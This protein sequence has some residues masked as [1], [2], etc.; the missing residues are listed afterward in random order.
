MER[1]KTSARE[2]I[3]QRYMLLI[4]VIGFIAIILSLP[5]IEWPSSYS[6][7]F[8][9]ILFLV[10]T[11]F[12]SIPIGKGSTT[13]GFPIVFTFDFLF[14][15]SLTLIVYSLVV[16]TINFVQ[17][18]PTRVAFFNSA[19]LILSF[20]AAKGILIF[21]YTLFINET[22]SVSERVT[23]AIIFTVLFYIFNELFV[24]IV[25]WI[26]PQPYTLVEWKQRVAVE[27]IGMM[28]SAIYLTLFF[29]LGT[30]NR[31]E[32]DIFSF[33]FFFS[34]LV[35]LSL[36]GASHFK[37]RIEKKRLQGLISIKK[38]LNP[39]ISERDWLK[40]LEKNLPKLFDYDAFSI[41]IKEDG[42]WDCQFSHG[43][44]SHLIENMELDKII[45]ESGGHLITVSPLAKAESFYQK[46][47]LASIKCGIYCPLIVDE[48][49]KGLM[50]IGRMRPQQTRP[51][52]NEMINAL[53]NQIE[54]LIKGR[55][56][57]SERERRMILEE[58]NRIAREI[59]DGIAQSVAGTV[60][61]LEVANRHS[62]DRPQQAFEILR[63]VLPELRGSLK[64]IRESIFALRP[65]PTEKHGLPQAIAEE[66]N[67]LNETH[68]NVHIHLMERGNHQTL[69]PEIEKMTF[70]IFK[71]SIQNALKHASASKI[72]TILDYQ[73]ERV[74]MNIK[75]NGSGFRLNEALLK[76]QKGNHFGILNMNEEASKLDA[77]LEINSFV[78]K[79]TN[80]LL[81]TPVYSERGKESDKD[82]DR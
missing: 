36:I 73:N 77:K 50:I 63:K 17:R 42:D 8:L 33:F 22:V 35:A 45:N 54:V 37:L 24:D 30:E 58:R 39:R 32:V 57:M 67:R 74:V 53:G 7:L 34:P 65:Y 10:V 27:F 47:F 46:S 80:I 18:R 70:H 26:R 49:F 5:Y 38:D 44:V 62:M 71:E 79:G 25:L 69:S 51:E 72:T 56:L 78:G 75:D 76:A 13:L 60:M 19:Q 2:R 82:N 14:G 1:F 81:V 52:E 48:E 59:H 21:I 41:W 43:A 29:V 15:L 40:G 28:L 9:L 20:L 64:E 66:V 6:I 12:F 55:T 68:E 61:K 4:T 3:A 31:G 16:L 23:Y 11:E